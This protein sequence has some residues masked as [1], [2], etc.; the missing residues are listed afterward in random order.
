MAWLAV[1]TFAAATHAAQPDRVGDYGNPLRLGVE[2]AAAFD[3]DAVLSGLCRNVDVLLAAHPMAPLETYL[4]TLRQRAEAGYH[5]AGFLDVDVEVQLDPQS[6]RVITRVEEGPRYE[7]GDVRVGKAQAIASAALV[8]RLTRPHPPAD[9]VASSFDR[10]DGETVVHWV[11][12]EGKPAEMAKPAWEPGQAARLAAEDRERLRRQVG[13]ALADLGH[14]FAEF[15]VDFVRD[16]EERTVHLVIEVTDEGPAVRAKD[17]QILGARKNSREEILAYLNLQPETVLTRRECVRIEHRLW[18]S[19]RFVKHRVLPERLVTPGEPAIVRIE[20][21]EYSHAP[22]LCEE[23]SPEERILMKC[24]HWLVEGEGRRHDIAIRRPWRDDGLEIVISPDRGVLALVRGAPDGAE[25]SDVQHALILSDR[26]VGGYSAARRQRILAPTFRAELTGGVKLA[27]NPDADASEG[28]FRVTFAFGFQSPS[29][30]ETRPPFRLTTS[31]P[32]VFFVALAHEHDA[33]C[34]IEDGVLTVTTSIER[35]RVDAES[36]RLLEYSQV[37]PTDGDEPRRISLEP[38]LFERRWKEIERQSAECENTFDGDR[39]VTSWLSYVLDHDFL[40]ELLRSLTAEDV[41]DAPVPIAQAEQAAGILRKVLDGNVLEPVD[42]WFA[43]DD[44]RGE[45]STRDKFVVPDRAPASQEDVA[46]MMTGVVALALNSA[47]AVFPRES[48]P[49]LLWRESACVVAK[50]SQYTGAVLERLYTS[51]ESGPIC[52]LVTASLLNRVNAG[53]AHRFAVRGLE[54]LSLA[55]FRKDYRVFLDQDAICGKCVV[56]LAEALRNLE[57]DETELLASLCF[58]EDAAILNEA[59]RCLRER[60]GVPI[61]DALPG[62]LDHAWEA[63]LR[64]RVERALRGLTA[65]LAL[66]E[67]LFRPTLAS[68]ARRGRP[69]AK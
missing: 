66:E 36:G 51:P 4:Q 12:E 65:S 35:I 24:R 16:P 46:K 40:W 56:R 49:W 58:G 44:R 27:V 48:W 11:D 55:D 54:R 29:A 17:I 20:L 37:S 23:L 53:L 64:R 13:L 68:V 22:P 14:F 60:P 15:D 21:A 30:D 26:C 33:D 18:E 10:R 9:A 50:R 61:A 39:P 69:P 28:P 67:G 62:A 32:P 25:R 43:R 59:A 52:L 57:P 19:A 6:G 42:R 34:S 2:G 47:D 3:A 38:N 8:E 7:A 63:G 41:Q 31:F 5:H 45:T 1:G